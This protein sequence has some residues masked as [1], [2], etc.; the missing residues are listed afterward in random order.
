MIKVALT[1]G[2]GSGKTTVAFFFKELGV[3]IYF[4]DNE[5]KRLM[6]SSKVIKRKLVEEFGKNTY[7]KNKLNKPFLAKIIF[8][9]K[10]KL[11]IINKIVHPVVSN[12]FKIWIRKQN[13]VYIIQENAILFENNKAHNFDYIITV[14]APIEEKIKRVIARDKVSREQVLARMKSQ[15]TDN[16][17]IKKSNAV[18]NNLQLNKTKKQVVKI[19]KKLIELSQQKIIF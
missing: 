10:E 16:E 6:Q 17:K 2:I 1:G 15:L 5:A 4:A 3:P 18:I 11:E 7:I 19:H 9:N 14:T 13:S 8:N 12:S